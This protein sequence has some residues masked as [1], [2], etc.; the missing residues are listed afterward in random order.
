[1][2]NI[3]GKITKTIPLE[4]KK[5]DDFVGGPESW[6]NVEQTDGKLCIP[7]LYNYSYPLF[8]RV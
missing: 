7:I 5:L 1:V 2:F 4:R 6:E 8:S 3:E